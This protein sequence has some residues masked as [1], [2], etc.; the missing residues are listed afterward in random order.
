M[1]D[2]KNFIQIV[3]NGTYPSYYSF[4]VA[5]PDPRGSAIYLIQIRM[6]F[7]QV[8]FRKKPEETFE[9]D[10]YFLFFSLEQTAGR[11]PLLWTC[12]GF[13]A[14]PFPGF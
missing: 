6:R 5:D 2:K 14:D 9:R 11:K 12:I 4:L 10:R 8:A 3:P 1:H 13:S 7:V